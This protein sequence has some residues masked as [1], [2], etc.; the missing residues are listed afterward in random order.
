MT[1]ASNG[2]S[3]PFGKTNGT[4]G[5]AGFAERCLGPKLQCSHFKHK[6]SLYCGFATLER[7]LVLVLAVDLLVLVV[8]VV[9]LVSMSLLLL[10]ILFWTVG[11]PHLAPRRGRP[12]GLPE[13]LPVQHR[14]RH[15]GEQKPLQPL[16][17][18]G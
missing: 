18:R 16:S 8:L 10:L 1:E 6:V 11:L 2:T 5:L 13:R 4:C 3:I 15:R 14:G 9:V 17:T 7:S 12:G